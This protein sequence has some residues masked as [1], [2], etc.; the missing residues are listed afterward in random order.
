MRET[1][2]WTS[3]V[4][5]DTFSLTFLIVLHWTFTRRHIVLHGVRGCCKVLQDIALCCRVSQGGILCYTVSDKLLLSHYI[6]H[7][8][9]SGTPMIN[10]SFI[11]RN[12]VTSSSVQRSKTT[13]TL[14][15]DAYSPNL[16]LNRAAFVKA[17]E[18]PCRNVGKISERDLN[19]LTKY[20]SST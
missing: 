5:A 3:C 1:N 14:I 7:G 9:N 15:Q 13:T 4:C 6:L 19:N 12:F 11:P 8:G 10:P 18:D 2:K 20:D 17:F 16:F